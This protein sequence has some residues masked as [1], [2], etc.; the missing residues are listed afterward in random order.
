MRHKKER[1]LIH[2]L[3]ITA[4]CKSELCSRDLTDKS[5][6]GIAVRNPDENASIFI[7]KKI[8]YRLIRDS[9]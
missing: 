6:S 1:P 2:T 3:D 7:I 8:P 4:R 5:S 9:Q